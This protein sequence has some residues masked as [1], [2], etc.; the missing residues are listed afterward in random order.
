MTTWPYFYTDTTVVHRYE[1]VG[2]FK[3]RRR[4][5]VF[6]V[7]VNMYPGMIDEKDLAN[8]YAAI[9]H[10]CATKVYKN[11]FWYFGVEYRH[12]C[13]SGKNGDMTHSQHGRSDNCLSNYSVGATW[14][15]FVYRFVEGN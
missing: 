15:I 5:R 1:P 12:Q 8:S 2:C 7:L 10:A 3:D 4:A 14:T 11:G 6:S 9:I 13:W